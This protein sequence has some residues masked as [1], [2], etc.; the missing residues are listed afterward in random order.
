MTDIS[1]VNHLSILV[2]FIVILLSKHCGRFGGG[3]QTIPGFLAFLFNK[4]G[5]REAQWRPLFAELSYQVCYTCGL[6]TWLV[7]RRRRGWSGAKTIRVSEGKGE[8]GIASLILPVSCALV[9]EEQ[10]IAYLL[11]GMDPARHLSIDQAKWR[12]NIC[13]A[14]YM[15]NDCKCVSG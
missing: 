11:V 5:G 9:G 12:M 7:R 8:G 6:G 10:P 14:Y 3:Q 2:L 13:A 15:K 4:S 1:K